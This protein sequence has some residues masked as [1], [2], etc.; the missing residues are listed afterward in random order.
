MNKIISNTLVGTALLQ[1]PE[2]KLPEDIDN[3]N[4]AAQDIYSFCIM[5][6]QMLYGVVLD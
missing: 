1:A 4:F 5:L 2:V 6:L 3:L